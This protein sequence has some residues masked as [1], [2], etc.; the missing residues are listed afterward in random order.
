VLTS[1]LCAQTPALEPS[2]RPGEGLAVIVREG[3]VKEWGEATD[4][5]PMGNLAKILWLRLEAGEWN[6]MGLEIKCKGELNGIRCDAPKGHGRVDLA[7]SFKEDCDVAFSVWTNVSLG[8]W[9]TDYGAQGARQ[10]MNE[11]F[12]PF[13][14]DRF[15]KE[16]ALPDIF[17]TEWF[18]DGQ[19]LWTSPSMLAQWLTKPAQERLLSAC[20]NYV[21]GFGDFVREKGD[22]W[23]I[24]VSEAPTLQDK[25]GKKVF[26][27]IGGN[28]GPNAKTAV[29][30]INPS[31]DGMTKKEADA[32]FREVMNIKK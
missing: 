14:G 19:L 6:S 4:L 8:R 30:R 17:G 22:K 1:S 27:I 21:L 2:L 7:K 13:F 3:E 9:R 12:G 31:P 18:A 23:W 24:K 15:P 16:P 28:G 26:W 29:L 20:R 11:V 10:R 25:S 32:R 5:S